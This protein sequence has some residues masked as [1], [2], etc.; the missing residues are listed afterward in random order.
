MLAGIA[1]EGVRQQV[2][3][4]P[5][6]FTHS[7]EV[8][9]RLQEVLPTWKEPLYLGDD[10]RRKLVESVMLSIKSENGQHRTYTIL[11]K[12]YSQC[13]VEIKCI[14]LWSK[15]QRISEPAFP[16]DN[17]RWSAPAERAI[18]TQFQAGE[19]VAYPL[20]Q[21]AGTPP[22]NV[23]DTA[24]G[25]QADLTLRFASF[26]NAKCWVLRNNLRKR[27]PCMWAT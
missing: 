15:E 5:I 3:L 19:V 2:Q 26:F 22:L 8:I 13:D 21:L 17:D 7:D 20:W 16:P 11:V 9:T 25:P 24:V 10:E 14:S 4:N 12:N 1:I 18:P 27:E 6:V 23:Y